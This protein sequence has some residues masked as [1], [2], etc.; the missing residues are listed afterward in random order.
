MAVQN[1]I[2]IKV[3]NSSLIHSLIVFTQLVSVP[4]SSFNLL[5]L[6]SHF[7]NALSET[8]DISSQLSSCL[9]EENQT[10]LEGFAFSVFILTPYA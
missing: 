4:G 5:V 10:S 3:R 9:A 6:P 1:V 2:S 8:G 7:C